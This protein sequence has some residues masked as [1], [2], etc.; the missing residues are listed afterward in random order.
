MGIKMADDRPKVGVGIIIIKGNKILLG[1]RKGSHGH[2][3]YASTGGHLEN[4]ETL[5]ECALRELAEEAGP[6]LQVKNLRF[7]CVINLRQ[8]KPKHYID[9][10]FI[11]EWKSGEPKVMEPDKKESWEWYAIDDLPSPIFGPVPIYV[12]AYKAGQTL[13]EN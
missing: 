4:G 7:L 6:N 11:A 2:G 8:Y 1:K 3:E 9:I 10:G 5:E 13:F 12:K